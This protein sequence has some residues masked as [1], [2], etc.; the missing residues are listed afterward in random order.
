VTNQYRSGLRNYLERASAVKGKKGIL[1]L[2]SVLRASIREVV[3]EGWVMT[4]AES[5]ILIHRLREP[6]PCVKVT[7]RGSVIH[8]HG[9]RLDPKS[10]VVEYSSISEVP[11]IV[12]E[13]VEMH[14]SEECT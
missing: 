8:E 11:S 10:T 4:V 1:A 5:S 9:K 3:P 6:F 7:Y 12:A 13:M 2:H 14:L